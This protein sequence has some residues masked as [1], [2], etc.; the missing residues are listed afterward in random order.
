NDDEKLLLRERL[1]E[2]ELELRKVLDEHASTTA[3]YEKQLQS[4]IIERDAIVEQQIFQSNENQHE[5]KQLREELDQLKQLSAIQQSRMPTEEYINSLHET[6]EQQSEQLKRLNENF[7]TLT[8]SQLESQTEFD[9]QKKEIDE[10]ISNYENQLENLSL[11]RTNLLEELQ[12]NTA[13]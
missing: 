7:V 1:N 10:R 4:L 9:R 11:E 13:S 6:I 3:M 5:M 12:K 2:V 8:S